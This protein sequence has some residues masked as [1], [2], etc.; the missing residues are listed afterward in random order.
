MGRGGGEANEYSCINAVQNRARKFFL[1]SNN[2]VN[3]EMGWTPPHIK[4]W[5][6]IMKLDIRM[7]S[8]DA[9]RLN[10]KIYLWAEGNIGTNCKKI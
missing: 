7:K 10:H 2:G 5:K 1:Q 6:L 3:G 4:Q 9:T 8:M